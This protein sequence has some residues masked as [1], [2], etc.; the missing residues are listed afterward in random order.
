MR[1]LLYGYVHDF[2]VHRPGE[3][4]GPLEANS[5][6]VVDAMTEWP[7]SVPAHEFQAIAE[8]RANVLD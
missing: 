3:T 5:A 4:I 7:T 1:L 2:D 8:Q 6:L